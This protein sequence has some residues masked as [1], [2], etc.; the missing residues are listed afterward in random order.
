MRSGE[1]LCLR[2]PGLLLNFVGFGRALFVDWVRPAMTG[3][4]TEGK[5]P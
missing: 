3:E 2:K 5:E 4:I 1:T